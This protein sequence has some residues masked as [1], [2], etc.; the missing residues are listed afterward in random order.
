MSVWITRSAP[1]NLRTAHE[2]RAL[3]KMSLIVLILTTVLL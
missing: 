1:D 2:L 3:G